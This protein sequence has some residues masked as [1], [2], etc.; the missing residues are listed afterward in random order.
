MKIKNTSKTLIWQIKNFITLRVFTR[1]REKRMKIY[2]STLINL[3]TMHLKLHRQE[4]SQ[5]D[6][7]QL[8]N[9][10]EKQIQAMYLLRRLTRNRLKKR[11][12]GIIR[13]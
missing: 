3:Q 9:M 2:S 12:K 10:E 8:P 11:K 5:V 13:K 4:L 6:Q 1:K 7:N